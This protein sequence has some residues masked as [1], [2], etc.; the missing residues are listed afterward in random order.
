MLSN[1]AGE[2]DSSAALT[3]KQKNILRIIDGLKDQT[4]SEEEPLK[5]SAKAEGRPKQVKWYK[6][7]QQITPSAQ[8]LIVMFQHFISQADN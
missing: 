3:V 7:G 4:I 5:L 8:L 1:A 2:C 6:N